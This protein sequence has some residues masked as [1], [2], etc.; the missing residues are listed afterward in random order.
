M[1]LE[2]VDAYDPLPG[3]NHGDVSFR[4][5]VDSHVTVAAG[6]WRAQLA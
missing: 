5:V 6:T 4:L 2:C 1:G 3:K